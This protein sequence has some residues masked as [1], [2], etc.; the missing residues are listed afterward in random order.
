MLIPR[1][2]F[3]TTLAAGSLFAPAAQAQVR[4]EIA[5]SNKALQM[6]CTLTD[7]GPMVDRQVKLGKGRCGI[8]DLHLF[9]Q[10]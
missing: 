4:V 9:A 10:R 3:L 8:F 2:H 5:R 1:R 7:I 6:A